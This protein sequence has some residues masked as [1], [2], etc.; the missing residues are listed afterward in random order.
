MCWGW[1]VLSANLEKYGA[2]NG[3]NMHLAGVFIA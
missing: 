3:I 2:K 1:V